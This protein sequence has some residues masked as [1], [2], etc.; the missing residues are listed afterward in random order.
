MNRSFDSSSNVQTFLDWNTHYQCSTDKFIQKMLQFLPD[1]AD[2]AKEQEQNLINQQINDFKFPRLKRNF[3][4]ELINET[5]DE[6]LSCLLTSD[7]RNIIDEEEEREPIQRQDLLKKAYAGEFPYWAW[8]LLV[9]HDRN[10]EL[11]HFLS[12]VMSDPKQFATS[13]QKAGA[14]L[15]KWSYKILLRDTDETTVTAYDRDSLAY[16]SEI[17]SFDPY[18]DIKN[19][20]SSDL[21]EEA[22]SLNRQKFILDLLI[23]DDDEAESYVQNINDLSDDMKLTLAVTKSWI[24]TTYPSFDMQQAMAILLTLMQLKEESNR[25]RH[26]DDKVMKVVT[27]IERKARDNSMPLD[28]QVLQWSSEWE[29]IMNEAIDLNQI[30]MLPLPEPI[31]GRFFSGSLLENL[32]TLLCNEKPQL[33]HLL[34]S[35]LNS[36]QNCYERVSAFLLVQEFV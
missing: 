3:L 5:Q 22:K 23:E 15:R 13:P 21:S 20:F 26:E 36:Y 17:I 35:K 8:R 18:Q 19:L 24:Q 7:L 6:H 12:I 4:Q 10:E 14:F 30:L 1:D 2:I 34:R 33:L 11:N 27:T 32:F 16:T 28:T 9:L 25:M 31:L 29:V